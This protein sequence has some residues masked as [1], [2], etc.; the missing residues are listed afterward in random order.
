M[1]KLSKEEIKKIEEVLEKD[2]S[3]PVKTLLRHRTIETD[4]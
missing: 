2:L 1:K 3:A 4:R